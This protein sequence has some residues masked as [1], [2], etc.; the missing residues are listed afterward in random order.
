MLSHVPRGSYC[1]IHTL[2]EKWRGSGSVKF[3]VT[4]VCNALEFWQVTLCINVVIYKMGTPIYSY[5]GGV[6]VR[7]IHPGGSRVALSSCLLS[8]PSFS[9]Q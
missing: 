9:C 5:K 2:A 3:D 6:K 7:E 1:H 8:I 4:Y